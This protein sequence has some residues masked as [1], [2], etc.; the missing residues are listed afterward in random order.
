VIRFT[1]TVGDFDV[2]FV[3]ERGFAVQADRPPFAGLGLW[4]DEHML[5]H[6]LASLRPV[7]AHFIFGTL[8]A[9]EDFSITIQKV[10]KFH[11]DIVPGFKLFLRGYDNREIL[12]AQ[13]A[14]DQC[15]WWDEHP[16]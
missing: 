13:R 4:N 16:R 14:L 1:I 10:I 3:T 12:N 9:I 11:P 7:I 8:G 5:P 2:I 6:R 15:L